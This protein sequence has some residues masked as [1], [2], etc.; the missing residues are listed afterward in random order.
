ME[1]TRLD[2]SLAADISIHLQ[3]SQWLLVMIEYR[4]RAPFQNL[5]LG[6]HQFQLIPRGV[7]ISKL[8]S[9][10]RRDAIPMREL[11]SD[12]FHELI[13]MAPFAQ[14]LGFDAQNF[15]QPG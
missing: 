13:Q 8:L 3:P 1:Q 11:R 14:L 10:S 15:R 12:L 5:F 7:A 6:L 2:L 9:P 4:V